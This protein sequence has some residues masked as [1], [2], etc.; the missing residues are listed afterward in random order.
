MSRF[1]EDQYRNNQLNKHLED[2]ESQNSNC[3]NAELIGESDICSE[4]LEHCVTISQDYE[5]A[6]CDKGD[7]EREL[8][9]ECD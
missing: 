2:D 8:E 7:A 4:C 3:C 9:R 1:N 6:M 5:N